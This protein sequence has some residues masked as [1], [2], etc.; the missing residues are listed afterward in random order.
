MRLVLA[1]SSLL[2][3]GACGYFSKPAGEM[4]VAP[5]AEGETEVEP[6]DMPEMKMPTP[7]EAR[8][9]AEVAQ[10]AAESGVIYAG[11]D[12]NGASVIVPLGETL[13]IELES[14]PTA[15]YVWT[16]IEAPG[17]MEAAGESTRATDPAYQEM[18]GFTGGNHYLSFDYVAK[19]VGTGTF[20]LVEGRP[21][22]TEEEP[23]DRFE[24]TVS[25][26]APAPK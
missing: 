5:P 11:E 8:K 24:L 6:T 7:G 23:M 3:L 9:A 2:A 16:V 26:P 15:G 13:R 12:K 18:A 10:A 20:K 14:I 1:V 4:N 21:W 25:A 22:E 17:F 19:S